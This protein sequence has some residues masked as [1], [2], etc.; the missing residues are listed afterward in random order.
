[1]KV[2][3][4]RLFNLMNYNNERIALEDDVQPDE[5][6]EECYQRIRALVYAMAGQVDPKAPKV[7]LNPVQDD[8]IPF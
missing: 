7:Q 8:D 2:Q 3:Y 6:P 4:E 1:M 5:T